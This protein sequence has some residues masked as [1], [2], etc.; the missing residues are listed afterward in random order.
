MNSRNDIISKFQELD[1]TIEEAKVYIELLQ[2]PSS[3]LQLS[4]ATG[5]NRTKV[6]RIIQELEQRSLVA[7]HTDDRGTFLI[8]S[9]PS[10]LEVLLVTKQQKLNNQREIVTQLV[11][12]L[13]LLQTKGKNAF[14]VRHY[15]GYAGL[16]QMCW[17]E[18]KTKGDSLSLGNGTIEQLVGDAR[19]AN[20]HRNRQIATGYASREL[21]NRPY[22]T[23]DL[24]ELASQKLIESSLYS[25]R[26]I[27]PDIIAFDSQTIIYND[28]VSIY[29]WK[30]DQK[31][32]IEII[33]PTY[34]LMMRQIF[35]H[36]WNLAG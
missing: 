14:V 25:F 35:E 15:E 31:L 36:Y 8:A 21:I 26:M 12:S 1:F 24:P 6:Y 4:N 9:D 33:S 22:S 23:D 3:H 17:H 5:V 18:L 30:H 13:S 20:N 16:K 2:G 34:A 19:W 27:S 32:G 7:R 11:P 10:A 28:T 29:H